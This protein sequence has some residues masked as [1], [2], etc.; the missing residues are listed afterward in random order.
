MAGDQLVFCLKAL[1][2]HL[3]PFTYLLHLMVLNGSQWNREC[4]RNRSVI[5]FQK[6]CP[7]FTS[8]LFSVNPPRLQLFSMRDGRMWCL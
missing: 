4:H 3:Q 1:H 6:C 7:D 5:F 8:F 2:T